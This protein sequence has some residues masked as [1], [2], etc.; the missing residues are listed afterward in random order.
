[1]VLWV[2]N[3][4]DRYIVCK[5]C[6][7][8]FVEDTTRSIVNECSN[9]RI[10]FEYKFPFQYWRICSVFHYKKKHYFWIGEIVVHYHLLENF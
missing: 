6:K 7:H 10:V 4:L 3:E 8:L 1:M 5:N 9:A 2:T